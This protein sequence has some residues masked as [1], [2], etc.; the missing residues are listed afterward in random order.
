MPEVPLVF[1]L[2][3]SFLLDDDVVWLMST[4]LPT[5]VTF[6]FDSFLNIS[7]SA[8]ALV[9]AATVDEEEEEEELLNLAR[10]IKS[11]VF[12]LQEAEDTPDAPT[13]SK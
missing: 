12:P 5:R 1:L 11:S 10:A 4:I 7:S 9:L 8:C 13:S 3:L 6:G 2:S